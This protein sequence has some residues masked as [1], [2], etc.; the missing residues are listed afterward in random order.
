M[1]DEIKNIVEILDFFNRRYMDRITPPSLWPIAPKPPS[2]IDHWKYFLNESI[3]SE[4]NVA[5]VALIAM[6]A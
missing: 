1:T 2:T 4:R 3:V 6:Q 5:L